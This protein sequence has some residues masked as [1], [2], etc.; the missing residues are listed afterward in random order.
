MRY[1]L[2][3]L[4]FASFSILIAKY[5]DRHELK[6]LSIEK[7][8]KIAAARQEIDGIKSQIG[9]YYKAIKYRK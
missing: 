9:S 6:K 1:L 3:I 5:A 2:T 4:L 7:D 8:R